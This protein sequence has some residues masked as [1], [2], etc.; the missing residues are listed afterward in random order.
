MTNIEIRLVESDEARFWSYVELGGSGPDGD[1]WRWTGAI[2]DAGYGVLNVS[3]KTVRS[4]RI[5][6]LI[7]GKLTDK[8]LH[9]CHK[10]D[11]P[12]CVNPDHLFVGTR[13]DNMRDMKEKGRHASVNGNSN[14]QKGDSHWSRRMP[15]KVKRGS[16]HPF[17]NNKSL[18]AR[19]SMCGASK[20]DEETVLACRSKYSEGETI[21]Q[22]AKRCSVTYQCMWN[23]IH[24]KTW[25]HV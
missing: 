18:A 23:L 22:L 17:R 8:S 15:D 20:L 9:V 7:A 11:N 24:R 1:C 25:T 4:H 12:E 14:L 10:C 5:S 21:N 13:A 19:G 6:A 2:N 3:R 16:S